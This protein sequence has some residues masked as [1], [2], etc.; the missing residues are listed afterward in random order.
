M[1]TGTLAALAL[2]AGIQSPVKP[3]EEFA[4]IISAFLSREF[5]TD[6]RGIEKLPGVTWAALPPVELK[7]CLPEGGCYTRQGTV[8]IG[9]RNLMVVATGARYAS[10]TPALRSSTK[11]RTSVT[12]MWLV[13]RASNPTSPS[14]GSASS[15]AVT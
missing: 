10:T 5:V 6:W 11:S 8:S 4:G 2:L 12:S 14:S 15:T 3:E 13:S 1:P 7:T 9:G